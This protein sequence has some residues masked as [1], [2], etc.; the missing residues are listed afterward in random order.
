[1]DTIHKTYT[2]IIII[3]N[4]SKQLLIK[5]F[6]SEIKSDVLSAIASRSKNVDMDVTHTDHQLHFELN[7]S[8]FKKTI[9]N[10]A[11]LSDDFTI[12]QIKGQPLLLTVGEDYQVVLQ[13][14]PI[15]YNGP[16]FFTTNCKINNLVQLATGLSGESIII[17]AHISKK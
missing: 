13:N 12:R 3:Y 15:T 5:F 6:D 11:S 14:I 8:Y 4:E 7:C 17:H 2:N 10:I 16:N 1:M 9:N